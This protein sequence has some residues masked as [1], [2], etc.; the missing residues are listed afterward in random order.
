MALDGAQHVAPLEASQFQSTYASTGVEVQPT[1]HLPTYH[2]TESLNLAPNIGIGQGEDPNVQVGA[3]KLA[4]RPSPSLTQSSKIPQPTL[5]QETPNVDMTTGDTAQMEIQSS[6]GTVE[7][8]VANASTEQT[9]IDV[10]DGYYPTSLHIDSE[11]SD[12]DSAL[13]SDVQSSTMSL[14]ESLY[15]SVMENGREYHKYKEGQYYLPNDDVEQDRLNLQ[16]HLW[17]LTL[18]GRLH[19]A[20]IVNPQCVLDIGTGTGLWALEYA[21][22]NP[23]ATV[24]GTGTYPSLSHGQKLTFSQISAQCSRSMSR[25]IAN[26]KSTMQKTHGPGPRISTSSTVVCCS[27]VS[28]HPA[29]SSTRPS[30]PSNQAATWKCKTYCSTTS[31]ST[32]HTR[33]PASRPGTA[34]CT[35]VLG[36]LAEIG[37]ALKIM[38]AGCRKR[39]LRAWWRGSLHGLVIRGRRVVN[40][41]FWDCGV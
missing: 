13:G 17:T 27:P 29:K 18:D 16:H 12:T 15:E 9:D 34:C 36:A 20:P 11:M 26:S 33:G 22:R 40:K 32:A 3:S 37:G 6:A 39:D 30:R 38:R 14:R 5:Q 24:V 23:S 19:L 4:S 1:E 2:P 35:R 41:N 10:E 8:Y 7:A 31:P 25:Q 28:K 21:E